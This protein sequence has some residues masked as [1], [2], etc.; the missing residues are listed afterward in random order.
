M[1]RFTDTKSEL[2]VVLCCSVRV[3]WGRTRERGR[4]RVNLP[5]QLTSQVY[6]TWRSLNFQKE[7]T[8]EIIDYR[9]MCPY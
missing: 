2:K 1:V 9:R 5:L 7:G 8:T 6:D 3:R 4:V